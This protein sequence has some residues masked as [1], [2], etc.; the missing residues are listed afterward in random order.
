MLWLGENV[1]YW[2]NRIIIITKRKP[3]TYHLGN[4]DYV[5]VL[6]NSLYL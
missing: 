5:N 3:C 4:H 6:Q 1:H 2:R